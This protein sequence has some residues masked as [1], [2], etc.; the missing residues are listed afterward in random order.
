MKKLISVMCA[1]LLVI[2][3]AV[4]AFA[5]ESPQATTFAYD[6]IIIPTPGGDADYEKSYRNQR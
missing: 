1:V 6:V 4:P 5:A 3:A 2:F